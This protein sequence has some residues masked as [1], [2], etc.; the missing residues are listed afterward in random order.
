[1]LMICFGI[2]PW[3]I[4]LILEFFFPGVCCLGVGLLESEK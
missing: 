4:F 2:L 3:L 1:M